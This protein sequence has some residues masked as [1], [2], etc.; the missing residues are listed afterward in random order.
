MRPSPRFERDAPLEQI[1]LLSVQIADASHESVIIYDASARIVHW[2]YASQ[3]LYGHSN[4]EVRGKHPDEVFG[5]DKIGPDWNELK[6]G[7]SWQGV[8]QRMGFGNTSVLAE[9]RL[10]ALRDEEGLITRFI[11][12]GSPADARTSQP[13]VR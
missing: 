5:A 10:R 11:E 7:G 8:V 3:R 12:Y 9:I 1:D 13:S 2:N 4:V 6:A